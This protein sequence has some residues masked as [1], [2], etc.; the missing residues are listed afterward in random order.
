MQTVRKDWGGKPTP[1]EISIAGSSVLQSQNFMSKTSSESKTLPIKGMASLIPEDQIYRILTAPSAFQLYHTFEANV[2][3]LQSSF[4]KNYYN[5]YQI[6][7]KINWFG[8]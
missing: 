6:I 2:K 5:F 8:V 4:L 3:F 1:S 7:L